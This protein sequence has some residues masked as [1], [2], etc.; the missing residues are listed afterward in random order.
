MTITGF[1]FLGTDCGVDVGTA[2]EGNF[3]SSAGRPSCP[4]DGL[5]PQLPPRGPDAQL[6]ALARMVFPPR[7]EKLAQS[8]DFQV[9]DYA[10]V[11]PAVVGGTVVSAALRFVVPQGMIGWL[12]QFSIYTLTPSALLSAQWTVRINQGPVPGFDAAQNPPGIANFVY[13]TTDDM[14]VQIPSGAV[15]DILITNL[16]G[17]AGFVVG[18]DLA[19]W[20]HPIAAEARAWNLNL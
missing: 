13:I 2:I 5:G 11:L 16:N 20:Y 12:Q 8:V 6:S 17:N 1:E 7:I 4:P 19:G 18:G 3:P 9:R 15:V 14:R 10:M